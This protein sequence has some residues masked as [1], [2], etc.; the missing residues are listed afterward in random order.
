MPTYSFNHPDDTYIHDLA[1]VDYNTVATIYP[2]H[3]AVGAVTADP[4]ASQNI[5]PSAP[6]DFEITTTL[7]ADSF[8]FYFAA[9]GD[10]S[11][12]PAPVGV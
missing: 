2:V 5:A 10:Y 11:L 8:I 7:A 12:V 9:T 1:D 6:G 3:G 4:E